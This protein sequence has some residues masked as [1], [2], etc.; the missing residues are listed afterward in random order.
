MNAL[1][2]LLEQAGVAPNEVDACC[3]WAFGQDYGNLL[4]RSVGARWQLMHSD[5]CT[6]EDSDLISDAVI[7]IGREYLR[8]QKGEKSERF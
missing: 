5:I 8:S 7:R 4:L 6:I 3:R 1:Q 2:G